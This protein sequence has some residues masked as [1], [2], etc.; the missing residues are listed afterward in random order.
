MKSGKIN[1]KTEKSEK[2]MARRFPVRV[3]PRNTPPDREKTGNGG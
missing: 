2:K 3:F 1:R